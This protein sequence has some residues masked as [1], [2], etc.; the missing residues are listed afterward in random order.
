MSYR[1]GVDFKLEELENQSY[2]GLDFSEQ[3]A[4]D[5][6]TIW[7]NTLKD[8]MHGIC[9][10]LYEN[11]QEPGDTIT[12]AQVERRVKILKPFTK[13]IR[14]F[15]CIEGNEHIPRVCKKHGLKTMVGAWLGDDD[16]KNKQ[17]IKA[18]IELANEGNV[19]IAAR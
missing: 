7:R 14:S 9:F 5:L 4:D 18:L 16:K 12:I 3:T 15:S 19:D 13:W 1:D 10:S 17:E 6:N 11:G 2:E 8:G